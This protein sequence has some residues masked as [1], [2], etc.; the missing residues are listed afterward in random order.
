M[1]KAPH[2]SGV[3]PQSQAS[4]ANLYKTFC[5]KLPQNSKPRAVTNNRVPDKQGP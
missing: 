1:P 4:A 2:L 3:I 5:A